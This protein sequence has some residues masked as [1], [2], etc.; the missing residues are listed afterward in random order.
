[1]HYFD[2]FYPLFNK[3]CMNRYYRYALIYGMFFTGISNIAGQTKFVDSLLH[4][5]YVAGGDEQK[6]EAMVALCEE[7]KS[8]PRDT[9]DHFSFAARELAGKIKSSKRLKDLAELAVA[10]DYF[11]WGW[12]D[13]TIFTADPVI[14]GNSVTKPGERNIYFKASRLKAMAYASR[15]H[16][17]EALAILYKIVSEA[18]AY[19]DSLTLSE[20]TNSIGSIALAR[21]HPQD[22][23]KWL[24]RALLAAGETPR[25]TPVK[26]AVLVNVADAYHQLGKTDSAI[27]YIKKGIGLFTQ[28]EN[29]T[30]L[31]LALQKQASI[32]TAAGRFQEAEQSLKDMIALRKTLG[33][34]AMYAGDNISLAE[35]YLQTNQVKKAIQLC[36]DAL[37]VGDV[38]S[39]GPGTAMSFSNAITIRLDY[40]Q[41]LARC[42]KQNGDARAY[43][44]T[45]E[46]IL[47]AKDS[48]YQYNSVQAIAELQTKYEVQKKENTIIQQKLSITRKSNLFYAVIGIVFFIAVVAVIL[49]YGYQKREK[50][51]MTMMLEKE[52]DLALRSVAK[53]EENERKRIAADLHDNLGAYAASIVSNVDL[54]IPEVKELRSGAALHELRNNSQAIV[55][56]LNDTI[57][58]LKK[59]GLSLI[60]ISDRIK[61][62]IQR[63]QP[64]Y[65]GTALNVMEQIEENRI[66]TPSQAFHLFRIMQEA[67]NNAL[68]HGKAK[69]IIV[70]IASGAAGWKITISDDGKGMPEHFSEKKKGNGLTNM[71][72]RAAESGWD[73]AWIQNTPAGAA[74]VITPTTN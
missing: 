9:L 50:M 63:I 42:Y 58:A 13:S 55:S 43:R 24:S 21:S 7:Y 1:M 49:F 27:F 5:I 73:I 34:G 26:A 65:P 53:A 44:H 33:D 72:Q 28:A 62:F 61:I 64:S 71:Q 31:A 35:F 56:Q 20:N 6:L 19:K 3:G 29:L 47:E 2:Y 74:V 36:K 70:T 4:V 51:K 59:D 12:A 66:L 57:W 52:K 45:L 30:S 38:R 46:Q 60:D 18:E 41:M 67:I 11:R 25:F 48:L 39:P 10:Y 14:A 68:R 23:L 40:Y 16:F 8:I 15:S 17:P 54:I 22:A 69:E 37:V 32:L